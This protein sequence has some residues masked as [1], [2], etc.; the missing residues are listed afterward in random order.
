[1]C[2]LSFF[3]LSHSPIPTPTPDPNPADARPLVLEVGKWSAVGRYVPRRDPVAVL[4]SLNS[5]FPTDDSRIR[6]ERL[7]MSSL[8]HF[9]TKPQKKK[10]KKK[11]QTREWPSRICFALQS[12]MR[13][14][15]ISTLAYAL[16][17]F[18]SCFQQL[19]FFFFFKMYNSVQFYWVLFQC[20]WALSRIWTEKYGLTAKLLLHGG[21][22]GISPFLCLIF[23]LALCFR[24]WWYFRTMTDRG[25][26]RFTCRWRP[27]RDHNVALYGAVT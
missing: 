15:S 27:L 4:H 12:S 19:H 9:R 17:L 21:S 7:G 5:R 6:L 2:F 23:D 1:M 25:T 26:K 11:H 20:L 16:L 14:A 18:S 8:Q 13:P 3:F 22:L 10:V 24:C